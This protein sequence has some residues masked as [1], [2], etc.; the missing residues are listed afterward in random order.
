MPYRHAWL[1]VAALLATTLYAFWSGFLSRL[2]EHGWAHHLHGLTATAWMGLLITQGLLV[3]RRD[4]RRHRWLGRT[5]LVLAPLFTAAG[6]M[7]LQTMTAKDSRF[8]ETFGDALCFV[9]GLATLAFAGFCYGA[10]ANRRNPTLHGGYLLVTP[11]L[12][13]MAVV[14]RLPFWYGPE[15]WLPDRT[16]QEQFVISFDAAMVL[17]LAAALLMT[18]RHRRHPQ[19]FL[20]LGAVTLVQGIGFHTL[21]DWPPWKAVADAVAATPMELVGLVGLAVGTLAVWQGWRA[22]GRRGAT[23]S[24]PQ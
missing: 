16:G 21:G 7:M 12:L 20:A 13:V 2:G 1:A 23:A 6:F 14:T 3:D 10:L 22:G 15:G 24:R 18:L 19:P 17:V 9:D 8:S 11:G 4:F 5:M